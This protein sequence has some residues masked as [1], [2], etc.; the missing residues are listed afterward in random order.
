MKSFTRVWVLALVLV[1][2]TS[3][4]ACNM[5]V[6]SGSSETGEYNF[7]DFDSV[8]LAGTFRGTIVQGDEYRVV[9]RVDDNLKD[10]LDIEQRGN[11]VHFGLDEAVA[12]A[13]AIL[14]VDIV[15]P[16]LAM[17]E[18]SGASSANVSGFTTDARLNM[19]ASGASRIEG[20]LT[21][22]DLNAVAS[23]ASR[24]ELAGSGGNLT[25]DASGGSRIDLSQFTTADASVNSS[26]GS[27]IVVNTS[28][29]LDAEA[30]GASTVRYVGSPE[31]GRIE[32]NGGSS[33]EAQ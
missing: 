33:V 20:T 23:G 14:E 4:A 12:A 30:T 9:V 19:E 29:R 17:L 32:E 13:N 11:M 10:K 31:L 1:L 27:S 5:V 8:E 25:A 2:A 6:G 24:I 15:M 28:G 22:G 3:L 16:E 21:I 26:G 7:T 18:T